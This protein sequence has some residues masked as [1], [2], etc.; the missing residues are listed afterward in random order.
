MYQGS[1]EVGLSSHLTKLINECFNQII[2][3]FRKLETIIT[4]LA[5]GFSL[6]EVLLS[7]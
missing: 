5:V 2:G 3:T 4:Y 6:G 1:E 7:C